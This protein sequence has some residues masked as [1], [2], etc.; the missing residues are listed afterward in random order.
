MK[1]FISPV[2]TGI[3]LVGAVILINSCNKNK[4]YDLITPPPQV[5]FIGSASQTYQVVGSPAPVYKINIGTT[6][7]STTDRKVTVNVSS[8][9]GAVAGTHY[10]IA[11]GNTVTIPAGQTTASLNVQGVSSFYTG[12]RKDTLVFTLAQPDISPAKFSDTI[13]LLLRGACLESDLTSTSFSNLLGSYTRT[14]ENGT[15]GPYTTTLVSVVPVNSTSSKASF[16]NIYDSGI[17]GQ[18]TFTYTPAGVYTLTFA[19]QPTG[20]SVGG[21]P[22]SLRSTPATTSTFTFCTPTFTIYLDLYTSAGL[23]DRWVMTTSR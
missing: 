8:P 20:F 14:F 10:S 16:T 15:Y 13:K 11:G 4:P 17:T 19:D 2:I 1:R 7:V 9:T 12:N 3:V 23:Y 5:H 18:A 22:L 6:D 21:L